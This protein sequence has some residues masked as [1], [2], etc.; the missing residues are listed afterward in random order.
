VQLVGAVPAWLLGNTVRIQREY[1][2]RLGAETRQRLLDR[3]AR[4]RAEE[5]L[6]VSR[7]VHDIV[8]HTLSMIA[9]R[10]GVARVLLPSQPQEAA[11]TLAA[12]ES[13]SRAA[14]DELRAVLKQTRAG[15]S[16][17]HRE[18]D[19]SQLPALLDTLHEHG[20][21]FDLHTYGTAPGYDPLLEVSA[22]RI[23]QEAITNVVKHAKAGHVQV[24]VTHSSRALQLQIR[25]DGR[26]TG[27]AAG[28]DPEKAVPGSALGLIGMRE[29]ADLFG[30]S[31]QAGPGPGGGFAVLAVL[32][33][34]GSHGDR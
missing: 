5:R 24:E 31:I 3:D 2:R 6:R 15:A 4:I 27:P 1:R 30:G 11:E 14:L 28:H 7:D 32:P 9:V 20:L 21:T 19:L 34:G 25:D 29:R 33:I 13:A 17:E 12:I 8:S 10:S 22:Y 26:G 23:V 18:P 16:A